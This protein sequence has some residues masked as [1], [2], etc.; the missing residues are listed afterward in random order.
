VLPTRLIERVRQGE[1]TIVDIFDTVTIVSL[2][3]DAIPEA[4]GADQDIVLEITERINEELDELMNEHGLERVRRS[5]GSE[6]YVAGL[7][8]DDARAANAARFALGAVEIVAAVGAE[9]GQPLTARAG[10]SAGDV[11]TGV[12][13]TNQLAFGIWGD[14][15]GVAVTL[16]SLARPS[17]VLADRSVADELGPEWDIGPAEELPGLADD[18]E[19]HVVNGAFAGSMP[20]TPSS[21]REPSN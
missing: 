15:P 4:T 10:L 18:I 17:Q 3:V 1:Q 16:D 6:L 9:F 14:P 8:L 19:A 21:A 13:G 12:L 20:S 2:T 11:A 7:D 5:T